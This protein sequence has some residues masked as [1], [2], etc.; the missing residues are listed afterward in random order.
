MFRPGVAKKMLA[1]VPSV[2]A[3]PQAPLTRG[4]EERLLN[5]CEWVV[6]DERMGFVAVGL[7]L[8]AVHRFRLYLCAGYRGFEDYYRNRWEMTRNR[9]Y[10][11]MWA[12]EAAVNLDACGEFDTLPANEGQ[13]RP[14]TLLQPAEQIQVWKKVLEAAGSGRVTGKL[15]AETVDSFLGKGGPTFV[16][17]QEKPD[18]AVWSWDPV[19]GCRHGCGCCGARR[20]A[21]RFPDRFPA[22]FEP[23]FHAERLAAPRTTKLSARREV[24]VCRHGDLLGDW[25]PQEWIDAVL[26]EVRLAPQ[27]TFQFLTRNPKRAVE[28]DWPANAWVGATVDRQARVEPTLR[29]LEQVEAAVRY[30]ACEPLLEEVVFPTLEFLDWIVVGAESGCGGGPESQPDPRWVQSLLNHAWEAGCPVYLKAGLKAAVR[31]CPRGREPEPW[32]ETLRT[33]KPR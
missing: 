3:R 23:Y 8:A 30:V 22:G 19:T 24:V 11:L 16:R 2:I 20:V 15:V 27:W 4:E 32:G 10:Q 14:L 26:K 33:R 25:V 9:G 31:E 17:K 7:A 6:E 21:E 5:Q 12:A 18:P 28:I 13:A 29:A 1:A